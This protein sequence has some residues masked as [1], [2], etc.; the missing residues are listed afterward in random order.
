M[1]YVVANTIY[2]HYLRCHTVALKSSAHTHM[3]MLP[4]DEPDCSNR[5]IRG[6]GRS[7]GIPPDRLLSARALAKE[8]R[9]AWARGGGCKRD[10]DKK[11]SIDRV[12]E[13]GPSGET[14]GRGAETLVTSAWPVPLDSSRKD[15]FRRANGD[16]VS[17]GG[18]CRSDGPAGLALVPSRSCSLPPRLL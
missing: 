4:S 1:P 6:S 5:E 8:L 12:W 13:P 15:A 18:S 10:A 9:F 7:C 2:V 3:L 17:V 14:G 16:D 11:D